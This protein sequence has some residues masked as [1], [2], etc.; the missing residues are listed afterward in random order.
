ME[1][2]MQFRTGMAVEISRSIEL[3]SEG[4]RNVNASNNVRVIRYIEDLK[5][6]CLGGSSNF[7]LDPVF[8]IVKAYQSESEL[9]TFCARC[10]FKRADS[11]AHIY[12]DEIMTRAS[13]LINGLKYALADHE[14]RVKSINL[15]LKYNEEYKE[16]KRL[17]GEVKYS[18]PVKELIESRLAVMES[19]KIS[20][21]TLIHQCKK[22]LTRICL[23]ID[24]KL[25]DG[26]MPEV[27][28]MFVDQNFSEIMKEWKKSSKTM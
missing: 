17:A 4:N 16:L 8:E 14:S 1:K 23:G 19:D 24:G 25:I 2:N 13:E 26:E 15:N 5:R 22:E 20:G 27:V 7:G 11:A 28:K 10:V 18:R 21:E 12:L 9:N 3:L 6:S